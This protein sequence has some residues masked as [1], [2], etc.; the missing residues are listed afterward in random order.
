M[1]RF[2]ALLLCTPLVLT[3]LVGCSTPAPVCVPRMSVTPNPAHPGDTIRVESSDVC[4]V[5]VPAEGWHVAVHPSG[6]SSGS[7]DVTTSEPFDGTFSVPLTLPEDFRLGEGS[8]GI[9][10][11]DYSTCPDDAS[12]ASPYGSLDVTPR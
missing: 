8:A 4:K 10:N 3:A 9:E 7:V 5:A 11:W 6:S 12:C 1:R 2:V